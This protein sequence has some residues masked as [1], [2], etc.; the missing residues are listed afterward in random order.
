MLCAAVLQVAQSIKGYVELQ[1]ELGPL[2]HTLRTHHT[3]LSEDPEASAALDDLAALSQLLSCTQVLPG[4]R[5]DLS[6]ARGLDY[7]TGLIYEVVLE[8]A[9]V[10]SIAAGGRWVRSAQ[11]SG[12]LAGRGG[13]EYYMGLR[14]KSI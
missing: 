7:Y 13:A 3:S 1:G 10:G 5:F 12:V 9:Q 2:I 6:L 14:C 11:V 4:V 8:G